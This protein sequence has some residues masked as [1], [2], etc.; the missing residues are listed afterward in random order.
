MEIPYWRKAWREGRIGFHQADGS[1]R[2]R[3][4]VDGWPGREP[5]RIL[6]PLC[7]KSQDL[8]ILAEMGHQV[9][10][11]E[12]VEEACL[13]FIAEN[14]IDAS[15]V[16][17]PPPR[18]WSAPGLTLHCTD[19]FLFDETGFDA[20]YD[21]A[22]LI[23]LDAPSRRRYIP[24]LC[25]RLRPGGLILLSTIEYREGA[26]EGPPF[27]V[28]DGEV[29]EGFGPFATIRSIADEEVIPADDGSKTA[30]LESYRDRVYLLE[31]FPSPAA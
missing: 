9:V 1:P 21:R 12:A 22:A 10:G 11:V 24:H 7:G 3:D 2:L 6:V 17:C 18:C 27:S 13:A 14:E 20:A 16:D 8:I 4:G 25:E 31:I 29:R 26:I 15:A 5:G 19:F 28:S 30:S 23:A